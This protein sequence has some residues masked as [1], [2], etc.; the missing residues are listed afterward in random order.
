[1]DEETRH[2]GR[3]RSDTLTKLVSR[4]VAAIAPE[5]DVERAT[6]TEMLEFLRER[7]SLSEVF[8][9]GLGVRE[10]PQHPVFTALCS[11][12]DLTDLMGRWRRLERFGHT[13]NR[14][15]ELESSGDAVV[16][17]HFARD[18]GEVA[19]VD[20]LFIWGVLAALLER[21]GG[22]GV[23]VRAERGELLYEDGEV[24]VAEPPEPDAF[25]VAH[26]SWSGHTPRN[27]KEPDAK[28]DSTHDSALALIQRD[29]LA[30][31]K[32]AQ[33]ARKLSLSSRQL[34]RLLR[35]E[36]TTFSETLHQARV[37][38]AVKLL[39]DDSLTLTDI[40]FCV[41]FA[42]SAHFTRIF[43]RVMDVPPS[44]YRDLIQKE[45]S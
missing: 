36:G 24:S 12:H 9:V 43:R 44:A 25:D 39:P 1:M 13:R 28:N 32:V 20:H 6:K 16:L 29:L 15:R 7:Q 14:T 38:A 27:T 45:S 26:Y 30:D 34:Q 37:D 18:G 40:A 31:W 41:G 33:V 22:E 42:D 8:A 19:M 35:R 10:L 21:A 4:H 17:E 2:T 3:M 11:V 5:F 23:E